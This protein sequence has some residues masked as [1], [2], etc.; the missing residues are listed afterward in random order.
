MS[1]LSLLH[2]LRCT[3]DH[4]YFGVKNG[5]TIFKYHLTGMKQPIAQVHFCNFNGQVGLICVEPLY[6]RQG[7]AKHILGHVEDELKQN[8]VNKIWTVTSKENCLFSSL[9]GYVYRDRVFDGDKVT[10]GGY[11]KVLHPNLSEVRF[12]ANN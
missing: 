3:I 10:G 5:K 4:P 12:S 7:V 8:Y 11:I 1:K 2:R 6:Q 9:E